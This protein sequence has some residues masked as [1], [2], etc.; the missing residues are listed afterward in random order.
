MEL[1]ER[2]GG[3]AAV[4]VHVGPY[5]GLADTWGRLLGWLAE[6]GLQ[7]GPEMWEEYLSPPEGDPATWRTRLVALLA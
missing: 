6:Q 3:R 7:P 2:P 4:A 5:E 1:E